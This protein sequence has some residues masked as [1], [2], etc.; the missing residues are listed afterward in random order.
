MGFKYLFAQVILSDSRVNPVK[1]SIIQIQVTLGYSSFF[2]NTDMG[3]PFRT[4]IVIS[5][6]GV[7]NRLPISDH[8]GSTPN[9]Y[10]SYHTVTHCGPKYLAYLV[11]FINLCKQFFQQFP[12]YFF[13][14]WQYYFVPTS[15]IEFGKLN[16]SNFEKKIN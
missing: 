16:I 4:L 8:I 6:M 14:F 10:D 12:P 1:P 13:R 2:E 5:N 3:S 9:S 7:R 15:Q 11:K